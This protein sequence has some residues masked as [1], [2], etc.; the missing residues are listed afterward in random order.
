MPTSTEKNNNTSPTA[1]SAS[2]DLNGTAAVERAERS[3]HG[4]PKSRRAMRS[5]R[6][7]DSKLSPET[8]E[9]LATADLRSPRPEQALSFAEAV[10][11]PTKQRVDLGERG[12]YATPGVDFNRET[13]RGTPFLYYTNGAAVAEVLIDR[14]T[15]D[16]QVERVDLLMDLGRHDQPGHRPRPGHRRVRPGHGLGDD[17]RAALRPNGELLSDSPTTYKIPN[18]T[19]V[20]ADFH[21]E[22]LDNPRTPRTSAERRPSASRRCSWPSPSG[23]RSSKHWPRSLRAVYRNSICRRRAKRS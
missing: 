5:R 9:Y 13:G 4:S 8:I 15:G 6:R 14:F 10:R 22:F 19:D 16:V 11:W 2:T 3:A 18:I 12:F 1:A 23:R 7:D 17:R 20:P 21:V